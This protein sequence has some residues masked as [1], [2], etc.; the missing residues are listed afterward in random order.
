MRNT[1]LNTIMD[2]NLNGNMSM[3]QQQQMNFDI[4]THQNGLEL[5]GF[6]SPSGKFERKPLF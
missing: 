1:P 3:Q 4:P 5:A 2:D 6:C